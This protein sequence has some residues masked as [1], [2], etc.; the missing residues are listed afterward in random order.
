MKIL[1]YLFFVLAS[2]I[3][4]SMPLNA[5]N[6][7]SHFVHPG[8]DQTKADLDFMKQQ[9]L[10]GKEPWKSAFDKLKEKTSLDYVI[11][12]EPHI[13]Q[14]A[15]GKPDI[16][17]KLMSSAG[18]MAYNCALV[19]Y[20]TGDK[21]YAQKAIEI[22]NAWSS[23]IWDFDDNNAKLLVALSGQVYCNAAEIIRYSNAGWQQKDI[24]SFSN[25]LSSVFY[26]VIRFYFPEANGNWNGAI[27]RTIMAISVFTDNR[28]MFDNAV[29]NY[30]YASYNGSILKYVYPSGQCQESIR[31][32]GH[33]QMG[34]REFAGAARIAYSQGVD[35][36][37]VANNRLAL[38]FEY[39][40]QYMV[41]KAPFAYGK[42]SELSKKL[43]DDYEFAY[44][45]YAASGLEMKY[46]K[47]AADSIRPQS[48]RNALTAW[49][50]PNTVP[51]KY[52]GKPRAEGL[53]S[54]A[55]ALFNATATA[56]AG[57]IVVNPGESVQ[58][59]LNKAAGTGKWVVL[60]KGVHSL[61]ES[62]VIPSNV[63]L[64]GEGRETIIH[65]GGGAVNRM[66]INED[67]NLHNVTIRD[68]L[69]EGSRNTVQIAIDPNTDRIN[70]LY[71]GVPR[72]TGIIF[73][74]KKDGQMKDL[75]LQNITVQNASLN[76]I[77][78]S[79]AGN[80]SIKSCDFT[81]NGSGIVPGPRHH[82]NVLLAHVIGARIEGSRF[83]AS[84]MGCGISLD[85]DKNITILDCEM[86][87]NDW[88][89]IKMIGSDN[90]TVSG[91]LIE[92]NSNGGFLA[93]YLGVVNSNIV[94]K[95]STIQYNNGY[96]IESYATSNFRLAGNK[97]LT[98]N[99]GIKSTQEHITAEKRVIME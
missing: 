3:S 89:G 46:T 63:T 98:G 81:D 47:I 55:G 88:Y 20:I 91:C 36:W 71:K 70:R 45:H 56:P 72:S 73:L 19:W 32:Q 99:G 33:V 40:A 27:E 41:D 42:I 50:A 7:H 31:D 90:I 11:Q 97:P 53:A 15:Y 43:N 86:A 74:S 37:S 24:D 14:G 35:L 10:L 76:G 82:H 48:S 18:D 13:I 94:V 2:F 95:N 92:A 83:V 5:Q 44:R 16:G 78:I 59:A 67:E 39:T 51:V 34:L 9:V 62:L 64:A 28:K 4:I 38:G 87:R 12:T 49:R 29:H 80:I 58:E 93:E 23:G 84:P 8:I 17:G 69:I 68:L 30:L 21:A 52:S 65:N 85:R 25:M 79:G 22:M 77:Y 57:S 26:P 96:G 54:P 66:L 75:V 1:K 6:G 60:K 61:S